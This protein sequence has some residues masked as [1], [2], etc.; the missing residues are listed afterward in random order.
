M[1]HT[2]T[3][4]FAVLL[5]AAA[6]MLTAPAAAQAAP[7]HAYGTSCTVHKF[8]YLF[9]PSELKELNRAVRIC[10]DRLPR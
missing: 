4:R 10:S 3:R 6:A 1:F 7:G 8:D 9:H 2:L 5:L